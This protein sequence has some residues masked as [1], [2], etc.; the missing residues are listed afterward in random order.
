MDRD[1][2]NNFVYSHLVVMYSWESFHFAPV[3][4]ECDE[5]VSEGVGEAV[6]D[7]FDV[8]A[9]ERMHVRGKKSKSE[10]FSRY[11][12]T[13]PECVEDG[14]HGWFSLFLEGVASVVDANCYDDV[15]WPFARS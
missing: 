7:F 2:I 15:C 5:P 10:E 1:R 13:F 9:F 3:W 8:V 11:G 6:V 12:K 14:F 4:C